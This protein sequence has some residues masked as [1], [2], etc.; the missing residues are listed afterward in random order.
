MIC[1]TRELGL[2]DDHDGILVLPRRRRRSPATTRSTLLGLRDDVIEIEINPDRAY[3]LSLRGVAREAALAYGVPFHDPAHRDVPAPNDAGY[4]VARRGPG[5]L[6]GLRDPHRHRLRPVRAD[7]RWHRPP[8]AAGRH[9]AD[10]AGRRRH[11]LRDARARPADPRLRRRQA[12]PARSSSAGRPRARSSPPSTASTAT[13][14]AEDLLITDD[15]GPIGLAGVMGGETTELSGDHDARR[16]RG[17]ALRPGDDLPHPAPAQAAQRGVQAVRARRRPDAAGGR[18]RP[19]RRAARRARRRHGH[20]RGDQRRRGAGAAP[21]VHRRRPA[22]A[23][24]RHGRSTRT[25]TVAHLRA[26]RLRGRGRRGA[27]LT[28]VVPPWRPDLT[29]PFDLVEEVARIVGYD[30]VPSVLPAAPAGRGLTR[31]QQLRRRVGRTLAGAGFVEVIT[32]PFVGPAD[33]DALGLAGRRPPYAPCGSPTRSAPS[34]R[35]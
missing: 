9:A 27:R 1:S 17:R 19:G 20:R 5:R 24:H 34:S 10:L 6:P 7:A 8:G 31:E 16:D 11:Q 13:L 35:S 22:G 33:F 14:S 2:G 30:H 12:Q 23:G 3:A 26:G 21:V 4:P 28:A 18:R 29:D 25:T 15:S 32:F